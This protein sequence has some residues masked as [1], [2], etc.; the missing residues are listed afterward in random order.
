MKHISVGGTRQAA[1]HQK[2]GTQNRTVTTAGE[3][4]ISEREFDVQ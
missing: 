2:S 4:D 1:H 3:E